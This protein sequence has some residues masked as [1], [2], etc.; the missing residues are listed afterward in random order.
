MRAASAAYRCQGGHREPRASRAR[1][2]VRRPNSLGACLPKHSPVP[3]GVPSSGRVPEDGAFFRFAS[4]AFTSVTSPRTS[5]WALL[6]FP[7]EGPSRTQAALQVVEVV[8]DRASAEGWSRRLHTFLLSKEG[9][10]GLY[11]GDGWSRIVGTANDRVFAVVERP[12][13]ELVM[14]RFVPFPEG[15]GER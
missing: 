1:C 7:V 9:P 13:P 4:M 11:V 10:G 3:T 2:W 6:I 5:G 8:P 14:H 12:H 15:G